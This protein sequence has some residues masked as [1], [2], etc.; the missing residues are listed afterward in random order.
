MTNVSRMPDM[1]GDQRHFKVYEKLHEEPSREDTVK[2]MK[3]VNESALRKD[4]VRIRYMHNAC[5]AVS[6]EAHH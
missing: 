6:E 3:E 5:S 2:R 1:T 4:G